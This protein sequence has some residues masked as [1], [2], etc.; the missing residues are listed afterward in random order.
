MA[1]DPSKPYNDLPAL[2]PLVDLDNK[3]IGQRDEQKPA[4]GVKEPEGTA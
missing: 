3:A 4:A 1:F 2:P